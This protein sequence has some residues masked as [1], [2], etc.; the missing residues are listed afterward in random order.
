MLDEVKEVYKA[1]DG[2]GGRCH[3]DKLQMIMRFMLLWAQSEMSY[4]RD[5][6]GHNSLRD[7]ELTYL[8]MEL[9][10]FSNQEDL[11][12]WKVEAWHFEGTLYRGLVSVNVMEHL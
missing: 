11:G 2:G 3:I 7:Q 4:T 5:A 1:V 6:V 9:T 8:V 10:Y 12:W